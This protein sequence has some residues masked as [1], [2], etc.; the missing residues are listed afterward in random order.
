MHHGQTHQGTDTYPAA[1]N[2]DDDDM[3]LG[4]IERMNRLVDREATIVLP[5]IARETSSAF[6]YWVSLAGALVAV[7]CGI[8]AL[9]VWFGNIQAYMGLF[10][11]I[12]PDESISFVLAGC[13]LLLL[14]YSA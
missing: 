12:R 14:R 13:A 9:V 1:A 11:E 4:V 3:H 7:V 2:T 6:S 8:I 5:S 10:R